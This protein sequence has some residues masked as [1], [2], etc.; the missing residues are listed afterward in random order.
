MGYEPHLRYLKRMSTKIVSLITII[1]HVYDVYGIL[2]EFELFINA[3][4]R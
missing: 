2:N 3:V 4:E 1:D